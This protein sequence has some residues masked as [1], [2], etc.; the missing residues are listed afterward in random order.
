MH[1]LKYAQ[2]QG[3]SFEIGLICDVRAI[4]MDELH[5]S[6]IISILLDNAIEEAGRK[7]IIDYFQ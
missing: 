7:Q 5:F 2:G 1:K 6:R 3:V 4:A